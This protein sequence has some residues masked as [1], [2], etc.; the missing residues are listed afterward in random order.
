MIAALAR[1]TCTTVLVGLV[2]LQPVQA[3]STH[4]PARPLLPTSRLEFGIVS[5]PSSLSWMT[6][7]NVPWQYRYTYLAGGVN[8]GNGWETWNSP[9]GQYATYYMNASYANN[10]IPVF[11]YYDLLQS[12][13]QP[14][15]DTP[16][17]A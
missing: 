3:S 6:S 13:P 15:A 10:Y 14:G 8:T 2:A 12:T 7:S 11:P 4:I 9:T 1:L 5:E 16:R 17:N